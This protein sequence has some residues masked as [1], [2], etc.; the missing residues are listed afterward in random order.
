MPVDKSCNISPTIFN[1]LLPL[2]FLQG[3]SMTQLIIITGASRGIGLAITQK[4]C[5]KNNVV[6]GL[7]RNVSR[8]LA[9]TAKTH[10]TNL[11]QWPVDLTNSIPVA[12][13][14]YSWLNKFKYKTVNEAV[15]INNAG[16]IGHIGPLTLE[17]VQKT[18]QTIRINLDA[19][20]QLTAAFLSAT[21]AWSIPKKIVNVSSGL[22]RRAMAGSAMYCASKA[23][24]DHFSRCVALDE[25]LQMNGAKIVSLAPSVIDT[26][27]QKALRQGDPSG[28]PDRQTFIQLK[29]TGNLLSPEQAAQKILDYLARPDFGVNVIADVRDPI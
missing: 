4:L 27:M 22:A 1:I 6:I 7:S 3:N 14:L 21:R 24:L 19:P 10:G 11:E 2:R 5:K 25:A 12:L 8:Q 20:M 15:L 9:Q 18:E 16:F 17:Y 23:G 29:E 26:D 28:F 13:Q